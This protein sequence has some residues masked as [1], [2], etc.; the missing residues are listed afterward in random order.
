M[1]RF[2]RARGVI[3]CD[4]D[5]GVRAKHRR[6]PPRPITAEEMRDLRAVAADLYDARV[7]D[8]RRRRLEGQ[9]L[10]HHTAPH[11]LF[12]MLLLSG[13]RIDEMARVDAGD[14]RGN[15]IKL[16]RT[17]SGKERKIT[18]DDDAA[19]V[20]AKQM[21]C[22]VVENPPG[23]LSLPQARAAVAAASARRRMP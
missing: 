15:K 9:D 19:R 3:P 21:S 10:A 8:G 5:Y 23:E 6:K 22:P 7:E 13:T 11:T 18:V 12:R 20:A 4:P 17:K 1:L 14:I 16:V 2:A